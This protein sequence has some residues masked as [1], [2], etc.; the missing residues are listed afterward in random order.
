MR[1][2]YGAAVGAEEVGKGKTVKERWSAPR[3]SLERD[4]KRGMCLQ[5]CN[6]HLLATAMHMLPALYSDWALLLRKLPTRT[7]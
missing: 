3:R 6:T 7:C 5:T 1:R 2:D 4:E